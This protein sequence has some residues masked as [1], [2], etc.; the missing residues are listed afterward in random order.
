MDPGG[1]K[2]ARRPTD[3]SNSKS[4]AA[5]QERKQEQQQEAKAGEYV[6]L[7][8]QGEAGIS[9]QRVSTGAQNQIAAGIGGPGQRRQNDASVLCGLGDL[10]AC[11]ATDG[12]HITGR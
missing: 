1:S 2:D 3:Q 7:I 4:G 6:G 5:E 9:S 11:H 10:A 12:R 8:D